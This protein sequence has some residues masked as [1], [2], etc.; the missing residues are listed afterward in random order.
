MPYIF[1]SKRARNFQDCKG[2]PILKW[3]GNL[4]EMNFIENVWNIMTK[5][6]GDQMLCL[7]EEIWKRVSEVWYSEALKVMEE[8]Y[9]SMPRKIADLNILLSKGRCNEY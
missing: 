7:K 2:I 3:P 8:L 5:E 9:N 4:P 1:K 6:F